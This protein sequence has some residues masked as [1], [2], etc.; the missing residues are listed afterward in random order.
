MP[1]F[2]LAFKTTGTPCRAKISESQIKKEKYHSLILNYVPVST[3]NSKRLIFWDH[4]SFSV[5]ALELKLPLSF[6]GCWFLLCPAGCEGR[7][8][9]RND[10][11]LKNTLLPFSTSCKDF[12][13]SVPILYPAKSSLAGT[14]KK[15]EADCFPKQQGMMQ[16]ISGF[17]SECHG[18]KHQVLHF[19]TDWL[20]AHSSPG[21]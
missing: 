9:G 19:G 6:Q 3:G 15:E 17:A 2:C 10:L 12:I 16:L 4:L 5:R 20:R 13:T 7:Q 21:C 11:K 14:S 1:Q 8:P 18:N